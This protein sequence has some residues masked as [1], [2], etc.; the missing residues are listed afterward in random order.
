MTHQ[1][2]LEQNRKQWQKKI[3]EFISSGMTAT[4]FAKSQ[5]ISPHQ[6][7]YWK[8]KLL[9]GKKSA[10]APTTKLESSPLIK[11]IQKEEPV[12][13]LPNPRWLAEFLKALHE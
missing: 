9:A 10:T 11:V 2:Q 3:N 7:H 8:A 6:F 13:C 5:D 4:E 1:E 12:L